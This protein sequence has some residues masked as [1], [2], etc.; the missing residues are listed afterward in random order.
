MAQLILVRH[1][2]SE[3][4][5]KG[6]WTGWADP[7]LNEEGRMEAK[8]TA[9]ALKGIKIDYVYTS[10]LKRVINTIEIILKELK[11]N[12][13]IVKDAA[14]NERNYGD[15]TG[16]NKWQVKEQVGEEEFNRIRRGWDHPI[17]NGES[18]KMVYAR[19]VP[20]YEKEI[21]P[22]LK[23]GK[24]VLVGGSGNSLRALVKFLDNISEE[25]ISEVEVKTAEAW[26]YE[27]DNDGKVLGKKILAENS[28]IV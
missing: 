27:I 16:K 18:L 19:A 17:P 23:L 4:N 25:K 10:L 3:W 28:K 15:F 13:K 1:G 26:V 5:D 9:E 11:L 12:I 8:R 6:I 21:L 2:R 24:N 7:D 20:Y 22:K 14:L